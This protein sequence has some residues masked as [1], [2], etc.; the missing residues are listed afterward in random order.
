MSSEKIADMLI[1]FWTGKYSSGSVLLR[2]YF[3]NVKLR[4][5][6]EITEREGNDVTDQNVRC[7]I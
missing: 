1:F 6:K 7:I 5:F 4:K 3:M 2:R